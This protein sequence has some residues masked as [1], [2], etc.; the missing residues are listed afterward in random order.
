MPEPPELF[1]RHD[2]AVVFPFEGNDD[3]GEVLRG[4]P[5]ELDVRW[6]VAG[7]DIVGGRRSNLKDPQGNTISW[8]AVVVVD[9]RVAI[10]SLIYRG[11]LEQWLGVGTGTGSDSPEVELMIVKVCSEVPDIK[12]QVTRRVLGCM[13]YRDTPPP[14]SEEA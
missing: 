12:G 7:Y 4:E 10:D 14:V 11:S 8:D 13:R 3:M 9:R 5:V 1:H 6:E 2:L